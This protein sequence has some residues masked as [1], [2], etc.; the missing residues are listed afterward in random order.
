AAVRQQVAALEL[1]RFVLASAMFAFFLL[2]FRA[3]SWRRALKAFGYKLP[4]GAAA[5]IWSASELARY[6]PGAIWQVVGRVYLCKPYGI[7]GSIAST[8][9]ILEI[10]IFLFA[11]VLLAAR[12]LLW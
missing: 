12:C 5:R 9:Q 11:N 2:C 6:L 8:S 10:C 1:W 7:P 3:L 4:C